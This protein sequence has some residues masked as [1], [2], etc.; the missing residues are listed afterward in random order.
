[1]EL[2][3]ENIQSNQNISGLCFGPSEYKINVFADDVIL[4]LL[5]PTPSP[6][7][8]QQILTLFSRVSY[9]KVNAAKSSIIDLD[10]L[11]I[12][13]SLKTSLQSKHP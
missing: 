8:V 13:S 11:G 2:L 6:A 3:A 10:H 1:M 9:Y 7:S 5:K 4:M 12:Q